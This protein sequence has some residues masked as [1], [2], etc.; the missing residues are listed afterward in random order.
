MTQFIATAALDAALNY[1]KANAAEL[2]LVKNYSANDSYATVVS[3]TL[4]TIALTPTDF[5]VAAAAADGRKYTLAQ[6]SGTATASS[7]GAAGGFNHH[8]VICSANAVLKVHDETSDAPIAVN[9]SVNSPVLEC[10]IPQ[11]I[12]G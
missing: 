1:I 7:T 4:V 5:T 3:N 8:W 9:N 11:A 6:K 12:V 2:R 10:T